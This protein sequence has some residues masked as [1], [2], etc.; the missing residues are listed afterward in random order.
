MQ[1][2]LEPLKIKA[3]SSD[4]Q[5]GA[6]AK[7]HLCFPHCAPSCNTQFSW[8]WAATCFPV[9][10]LSVGFRGWFV[11]PCYFT[12]KTFFFFF[13]WC[14]Q[15]SWYRYFMDTRESRVWMKVFCFGFETKKITNSGVYWFRDEDVYCIIWVGTKT[16]ETFSSFL[17]NRCLYSTMK[18]RGMLSVI[19]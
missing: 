16:K 1:D 14:W 4:A 8:C 5:H 18:M 12:N 11:W 17:I 10:R 6:D 9:I 13:W 15:G 7:C 3:F 19:N 2:S